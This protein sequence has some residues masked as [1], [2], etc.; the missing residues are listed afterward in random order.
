LF[1]IRESKMHAER[2]AALEWKLSQIKKKK[3]SNPAT[4]TFSQHEEYGRNE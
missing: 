2:A 1:E 3:H 4:V